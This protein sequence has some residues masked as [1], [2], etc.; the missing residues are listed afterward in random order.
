MELFKK[1]IHEYTNI[2]NRKKTR[3]VLKYNYKNISVRD[4]TPR[5][6]GL[7]SSGI[8]K[9][10]KYKRKKNNSKVDKNLKK[11]KII[12]HN[13]SKYNST[14]DSYNKERITSLIFDG[15]FHYVS[16]FKDYLFW[17][18]EVE[19]LKKYYKKEE[20]IPI[21]NKFINYYCTV[22]N[23]LNIYCI[24]F[25]LG[26]CIEVMSKYYRK[27][28]KLQHSII[29]KNEND[30]ENEN[31]EII[32][33]IERKKDERI[34][35]S[36][37]KLTSLSL[38]LSKVTPNELILDRKSNE[39]MSKINTIQTTRTSSKVFK[40]R[41][42]AELI[43][44]GK[45][46]KEISEDETIKSLIKNLNVK[47]KISK[48]CIYKFN[49]KKKNVLVF[50]NED[51][52]KQ[53][54]LKISPLKERILKKESSSLNKKL[55]NSMIINNKALSNQN[56]TKKLYI[57]TE[58]NKILIPKCK[59]TIINNLK[60][61]NIKDLNLK[62]K[63][64]KNKCLT[65]RTN[66]KEKKTNDLGVY[67]DNLNQMRPKILKHG[68]IKNIYYSSKT[69]PKNGT[70]SVNKIIHL[71]NLSKKNIT[72]NNSQLSNLKFENKIDLNNLKKS[73]LS[74]KIKKLC[75]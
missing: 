5:N 13:L 63:N 55:K 75:D 48:I 72:T 74:K 16:L 11:L 33:T 28:L 41:N 39:D 8:S 12:S 45:R 21:M 43:D 36:H 20:I 35:E 24:Y 9:I 66:S 51:K 23:S 59:K 57:N 56:S 38:N 32:E 68:N 1:K 67:F 47:K 65:E 2:N 26:D 29:E 50:K 40:S 64:N 73:S 60:P 6:S 42:E 49:G 22:Y 44:K 14:I 71:N 27:K 15:K 69:S 53:A 31:N 61:F 17:D 25:H 46:V 70:K 58:S 62:I 34:F 18:D 10:I 4:K 30:D 52:I 37:I 19:C 54:L 3:Q 7:N